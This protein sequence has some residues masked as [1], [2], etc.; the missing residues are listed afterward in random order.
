MIVLAGTIWFFSACILVSAGKVH[1]SN[2]LDH[3]PFAYGIVIVGMIGWLYA[4]L[5]SEK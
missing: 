2:F 5:K 1:L 4:I 3:V